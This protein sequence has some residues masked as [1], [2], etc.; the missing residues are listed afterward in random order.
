MMSIERGKAA[1]GELLFWLWRGGH[2]SMW[3]PPRLY[4]G[5]RES[6]RPA[7]AGQRVSR[8]LR[9][10]TDQKEQRRNT[11]FTSSHWQDA[12]RQQDTGGGGWERKS[13]SSFNRGCLWWAEVTR[14]S[15]VD[16]KTFDDLDTDSPANILHLL[17]RLRGDKHRN[18]ATNHMLLSAHC[19]ALFCLHST[20]FVPTRTLC[21]SPSFSHN[22]ALASI[23]DTRRWT[24]SWKSQCLDSTSTP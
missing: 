23:Y 6:W 22:T 1:L 18:C 9:L 20:W 8:A 15:H 12:H 10:S 7:G 14:S 17:S 24:Q 13:M 21:S 4:F 3:A 5:G 19:V 11:Q 2:T 16:P